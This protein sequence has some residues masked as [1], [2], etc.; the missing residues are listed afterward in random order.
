M[1]EASLFSRVIFLVTIQTRDLLL[2]R[3]QNSRKRTVLRSEQV[4]ENEQHIASTPFTSVQTWV[5]TNLL[6]CFLLVADNFI[7][8]V[9]CKYSWCFSYLTHHLWSLTNQAFLSWKHLYLIWFGPKIWTTLCDTS[10]RGLPHIHRYIPFCLY[11]AGSNHLPLICMFGS[12]FQMPIDWL[13]FQ[14]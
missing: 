10:T 13:T 7:C 3:E 8:G 12:R 6:L 11:D 9:I 4:I 2:Q 5:V 1:Q 14:F